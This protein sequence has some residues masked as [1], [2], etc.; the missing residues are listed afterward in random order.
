MPK[1]IQNNLYYFKLS[2]ENLEK[3]LDD[4]YIFDKKHSEIDQ[5]IQNTKEIKRYLKNNPNNYWLNTTGFKAL[6]SDLIKSKN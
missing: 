2:Q 1:N 6:F 4:F 5:Y 3:S